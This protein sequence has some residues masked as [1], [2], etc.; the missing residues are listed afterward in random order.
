[1]V[2]N[3]GPQE[4]VIHP[5]FIRFLVSEFGQNVLHALIRQNHV[6]NISHYWSA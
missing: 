1:M 2:A 4:I 5:Q 3:A 6:S